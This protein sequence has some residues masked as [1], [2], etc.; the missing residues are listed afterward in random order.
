MYAKEAKYKVLQ[1]KLKQNIIYQQKYC[2]LRTI[3]WSSEI[4]KKNVIFRT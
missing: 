1:Y 4:V 3:V 2:V